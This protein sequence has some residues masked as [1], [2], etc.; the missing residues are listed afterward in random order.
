VAGVAGL[1]LLAGAVLS[2]C[3]GSNSAV[4]NSAA[5]SPS[6]AGPTSAGNGSSGPPSNTGGS[7]GASPQVVA[8]SAEAD[9]LLAAVPVEPGARQLDSAPPGLPA[10]QTRIVAP[11]GAV[12]RSAWFSQ[13]GSVE[14]ATAYFDAHVP[15]GTTLQRPASGSTPGTVTYRAPAT[16]NYLSAGLSLT[17][18]SIGDGVAVR[19]VA[20]VV[21]VGGTGATGSAGVIPAEVTAVDITLEGPNSS[22]PFGRT[23][24]GVPAAGLA[25]AVNGLRQ[26]TPG[27][28]SCMA[29]SGFREILVFHAG[30]STVTVT[31]KTDPCGSV[32]VVNAG[33]SQVLSGAGTLDRAVLAALRL[34]SGYGR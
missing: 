34:P 1:T 4:S 32:K 9:R 14:S 18:I 19:A 7:V 6:S 27:S 10:T 29:D 15:A 21:P 26:P 20:M 2:G 17:V 28:V 12:L 11:D 25:A 3:A 33:I 8:A 30:G 22:K 16:A 23:L 5:A 13:P 31:V 24:T